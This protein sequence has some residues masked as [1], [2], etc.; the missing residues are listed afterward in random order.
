MDNWPPPWLYGAVVLGFLVYIPFFNR[1]IAKQ[2]GDTTWEAC[3]KIAEENPEIDFGDWKDRI[4]RMAK[5][6]AWINVFLLYGACLFGLF[7]VFKLALLCAVA[8]P[9]LYF[10]SAQ[11]F[12]RKM[13]SDRRE[14]MMDKIYQ[15]I[16]KRP[17]E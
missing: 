3:K 15:E 13:E 17:K 6:I 16:S 2:L 4:D 11:L 7:E 8:L 5:K 1:G 9:I 14:F 12:I 10:G